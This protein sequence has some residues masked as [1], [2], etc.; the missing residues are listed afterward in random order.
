MSATAAARSISHHTPNLEDMS[1]IRL[2]LKKDLKRPYKNRQIFAKQEKNQLLSK[3]LLEETVTKVLTNSATPQTGP[4]PLLLSPPARVISLRRPSAPSQIPTFPPRAQ[5]NTFIISNKQF[6]VK[7]PGM[8]QV[9]NRSG[10]ILGSV[11]RLD[12]PLASKTTQLVFY[13]APL[14]GL[15]LSFCHFILFLCCGLF[16]L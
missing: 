1:R 10:Q 2:P 12:N 16:I 15:S 4:S 9:G 5:H 11:D 7:G 8:A 6:S 14:T 13:R 3:R